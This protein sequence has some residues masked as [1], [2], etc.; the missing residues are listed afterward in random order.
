MEPVTLQLVFNAQQMLQAADVESVIAGDF[1]MSYRG[2]EIVVHVS[3]HVCLTATVRA[4]TGH[5][6]DIELCVA[7]AHRA[8]AIAALRVHAASYE[9]SASINGSELLPS[10]QK[11]SGTF[12]DLE[13]QRTFRTTHCHRQHAWLPPHPIGCGNG[14][15]EIHRGS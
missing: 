12:S 1:G 6:Q 5:T 2:V 9:E 11:R 10:L 8:L 3:Q 15:N 4:S 14:V 7:A 13:R